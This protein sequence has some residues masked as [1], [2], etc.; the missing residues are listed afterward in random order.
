MPR[1]K[2]ILLLWLLLIWWNLSAAQVSNKSSKLPKSP[3][4]IITLERSP[5]VFGGWPVY[6]LALYADGT[7]IFEGEKNVKVGTFKGKISQESLRQ[8]ISEFEKIDYFSLRDQYHDAKDGCS[9]VG[10]DQPVVL[11][12]LEINGKRKTISHYYGCMS[13]FGMSDVYPR[14]LY[15][16]EKKIDEVVNIKQWSEW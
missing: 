2:L 15:D 3:E 16:L 13:G 5:D 6:Q 7:V 4:P 9:I 1:Y 11:T 10:T 12:S 14:K 8:L